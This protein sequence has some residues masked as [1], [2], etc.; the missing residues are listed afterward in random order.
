MSVG[1]VA[2]AAGDVDEQREH[3]H[4]A[5]RRAPATG[6][7][8]AG[9][10]DHPATDDHDGGSSSR[11]PARRR[12]PSRSV[13]DQRKA[14]SSRGCSAPSRRRRGLATGGAVDHGRQATRRVRQHQGD[15]G[16]TVNGVL[17]GAAPELADRRDPMADEGAD[18]P[19]QPDAVI[20]RARP[21]RR[22]WPQIASR[23]TGRSG[24]SPGAASRR[25]RAPA[26]DRRAIASPVT[27]MIVPSTADGEPDPAVAHGRTR[28]T[29]AGFGLGL[30]L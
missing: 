22:P 25:S 27:A 14:A 26:L 24:R 2:D 5:R 17:E 23:R 7:P 12:D 19:G 1:H 15:A 3:E 6:P 8:R 21:V 18:E 4:Q 20:S 28:H 30:A 10:C 9:G 16:R 29:A 11:A 13:V